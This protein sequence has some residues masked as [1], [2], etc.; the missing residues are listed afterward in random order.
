MEFGS[1]D[2]PW[3]VERE[4]DIRL[5]GYKRNGRVSGITELRES[6]IRVLVIK[7][8]IVASVANYFCGRRMK[9][10]LCD[11]MFRDLRYEVMMLDH[12]R[13]ILGHFL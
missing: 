4:R 12:W 7:S 3:E 1:L 9:S 2:F 13:A 8:R 10:K 6:E 5:G 11:A